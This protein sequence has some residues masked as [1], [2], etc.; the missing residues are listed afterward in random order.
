MTNLLHSS[1]T[2]GKI[3]FTCVN[4]I[5]CTATCECHLSTVTN[6]EQPI[7]QLPPVENLNAGC[8]TKQNTILESTVN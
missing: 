2:P 3:N 4:L 6:F 7:S 1:K 8:L 5:T